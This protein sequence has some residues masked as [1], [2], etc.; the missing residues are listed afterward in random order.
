MTGLLVAAALRVAIAMSDGLGPNA[1]AVYQDTAH[2]GAAA[3]TLFDITR[4]D[5]AGL[6]VGGKAKDF[7]TTAARLFGAV[8]RVNR[9]R[10][11]YAGY[12]AAIAVNATQCQSAQQHRLQ[13]GRVGSVCVTAFLDADDVVRAVRIERV[14]AHMDAA[15]FR[16][17]LVRRYGAVTTERDGMRVSLGWGPELESAI[18]YDDGGPHNALT[19]HYDE[20]TEQVASFSKATPRTRITL[21]LVDAAW[22]ATVTTRQ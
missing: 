10:G 20:E 14:F 15:T 17:T 22:A 19:A 6:R 8:T 16:S 3:A 21:Q 1:G 11:W 13:A 7:E 5:V 4:L 12:S 2:R 9:Q 18:A